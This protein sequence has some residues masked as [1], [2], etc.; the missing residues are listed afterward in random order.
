M[1]IIRR[2]WVCAILGVAFLAGRAHSAGAPLVVAVEVAPGMDIAATDVRQIVASELGRP[3]V[4][5][6]DRT[7][8][9]DVLLVSLG[10]RDITMSLHARTV[11]VITRAIEAPADR[12]GR[13][14]S[15]AWLSGNLVRDQVGPIV[16][17]AGNPQPP[18][19]E[20]EPPPL[21]A[22][23]SPA[24]AAP[25]AIVSS[26]AAPPADT[27]PHATW[28]VTA[29]G[30]GSLSLQETLVRGVHFGNTFKVEVRHQT[31]PDSLFFGMALQVGPDVGA[32]HEIGGAAFIGSDWRRRWFFL[33]GDLG[34]G[35]E[36]LKSTYI[37]S[38]SMSSGSTGTTMQ[39]TTTVDHFAGLFA[40]AQG[41]AGVRVTATF[42]VVAQL[43]L[44]LSSGGGYSSFVSSLFGLRLR[45]P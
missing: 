18:P 25:A 37:S 31:S 9:E 33:E 19:A 14:R 5:S 34:L 23:E 16:A 11:P 40:R 24:A 26:A 38:V 4:G 8:A 30:G 10:P 45:L 22:A 3:V 21:P 41:T 7:Q 1:R 13:L 12:S 44:H 27:Y 6:R 20:T 15:I 29:V 2:S 32:Q 35:I 39:E 36:V 42:D 43:G 28:A 17:S